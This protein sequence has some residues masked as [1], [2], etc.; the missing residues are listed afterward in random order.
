MGRNTAKQ[1]QEQSPRTH[2]DGPSISEKIWGLNWRA[3]FPCKL[4]EGFTVSYLTYA[5][6]L[7]I[8]ATLYTEVFMLT[9]EPSKF[10]DPDPRKLRSKYYEAMGDFF[11][12]TDDSN[13]RPVG[14]S[15]CTITDW[16]S[17]LMRGMGVHPDY[18]SRGL[19]V[20]LIDLM[21]GI[22]KD[23]GVERFEGDVSPSNFT[24]FHL[25]TKRGFIFTSM[26][27]SERWGAYI[28]TTRYLDDATQQRFFEN[29]SYTQ[30]SDAAAV[31]RLAKRKQQKAG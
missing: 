7:P 11:L 24:Q 26:N 30:K 25:L 5:E 12:I 8:I 27:L 15:I 16:T 4:T 20:D 9:G 14:L 29:F 6:A 31:E 1:Q 13:N 22:L 2:A 28:R 21:S 23:H 10:Q 3:H 18:Q 19:Y 17:Y